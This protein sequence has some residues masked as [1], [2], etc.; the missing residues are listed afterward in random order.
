MSKDFITCPR[1]RWI[2]FNK[3]DVEQ[4][5]CG[6][7]HMFHD[8][9]IHPG[10]SAITGME[11][12]MIFHFKFEYVHLLKWFTDSP[13]TGDPKCIC[14]YCTKV[15]EEGEIP[16]YAFRGEGKETK[17]L[18]LHIN[19]AKIVVVEFSP[20]ELQYKDHPAF[21]EG[22][23]HFKVGWRRASNPYSQ[24]GPERFRLAWEAGWDD[25]WEKRNEPPST[26]E[27]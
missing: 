6:N 26:P 25:A 21:A 10:L 17:E 18:R 15:I 12:D 22:Q 3:N 16:L 5:Y 9:R 23:E 11:I 27:S 7:C 13:D 4:R 24:I 1:C 14:S 8:A 2:S 19:C 20:P